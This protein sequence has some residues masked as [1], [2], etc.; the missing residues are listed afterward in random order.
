MRY[1]IDNIITMKKVHACGSKDWQV[2]RTGAEIGI[3]CLGCGREI[4]LLPSE[5]DKRKKK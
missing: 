5:I 4:M 1:P 3:K 2:V